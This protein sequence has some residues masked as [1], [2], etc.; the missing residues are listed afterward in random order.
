MN[1]H[2]NISRI[3]EMMGIN[4]AVINPKT[5]NINNFIDELYLHFDDNGKPIP[6]DD[7]IL[8]GK[9]YNVDIIK[10][11]DYKN[12]LPSDD[13]NL[14]S[15]SDE[16]MLRMPMFGYVDPRTNRITMVFSN[17]VTHFILQFLFFFKQILKHEGVHLGQAGRRPSQTTGEYFGD[18]MD[19]KKYFENKDEIMAFANTL[20]NNFIVFKKPKT[21]EDAKRIMKKYLRDREDRMWSDIKNSVDNETLKKYLKYIYLYLE[22]EFQD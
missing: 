5:E 11:N 21:L 12:N 7:F 22:Q 2:E 14:P 6:F 3:K 4:E 9:K 20:V 10:L 19:R 13:K 1:L 15:P 17:N 16:D 18:V 8:M